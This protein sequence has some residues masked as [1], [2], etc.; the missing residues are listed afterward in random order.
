[1]GKANFAAVSAAQYEQFVAAVER[2]LDID[3]G[4]AAVLEVAAQAAFADDVEA[5]LN[6][7]VGLT[8]VLGAEAIDAEITRTIQDEDGDVAVLKAAGREPRMPPLRRATSSQSVAS[9]EV[10]TCFRLRIHPAYRQ[11]RVTVLLA[12]DLI[13]VRRR[14]HSHIFDHPKAFAHARTVDHARVRDLRQRLERARDLAAALCRDLDLDHGPDHFVTRALIRARN[15][16]S[17]SSESLLA[18]LREDLVEM[19][20]DYVGADLRAAA[21]MGGSDGELNGM[22]WELNGIEWS[23]TTTWPPDWLQQIRARSIEIKPGVFRITSWGGTSLPSCRD[24]VPT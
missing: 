11:L 19:G 12:L 7:S 16:Q 1:M 21:Q 2:E 20:Y 8:A 3:A 22:E 17:T 14:A 23:E 13:R 6:V 18:E 15:L 10:S 24:L 5:Q 4:L 9:L